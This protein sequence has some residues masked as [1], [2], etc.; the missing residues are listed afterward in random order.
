MAMALPG[1]RVSRLWWSWR[2]TPRPRATASS[3]VA[4]T[5]IWDANLLPG[6]RAAQQFGLVDHRNAERL[7]L[8]ELR[9]GV[10][11]RHHGGRFL[12]DGVGDVPA[13]SLDQ[14]ARGLAGESRQ[15][16]GDDVGVP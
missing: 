4:G 6:P 10:G 3:W 1:A 8:F 9:A 15:G 7:R 11:A 12:G 5:V 13:R 16:A 14:L 2:R